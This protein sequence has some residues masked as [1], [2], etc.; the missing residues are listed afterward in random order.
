MTNIDGY[1][2]HS[3]TPKRQRYHNIGYSYILMCLRIKISN[4]DF[5]N[6]R[7]MILTNA[8]KLTNCN[9]RLK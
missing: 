8:N 7:Y 5:E 1:Q 9:L 2:R 3:L 4:S 6:S